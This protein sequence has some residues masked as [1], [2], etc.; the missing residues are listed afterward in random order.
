MAPLLVKPPA[1]LT[2]I[3][4]RRGAFTDLEVAAW[5]DGR[6]RVRAHGSSD[7]PVWGRQLG[8]FLPSE[9]RESAVRGEIQLLVAYLRSIQ[10]KEIGAIDR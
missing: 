10:R 1:D 4:I 3:A 8:G 2:T 7:M 5:I 9:S 6:R